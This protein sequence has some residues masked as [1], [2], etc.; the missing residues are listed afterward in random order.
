MTTPDLLARQM[1]VAFHQAPTVQTETDPRDG[2]LQLFEDGL[3]LYH[4]EVCIV[5]SAAANSLPIP[6]ELAI[7][8][9][10][11][12]L[13]PGYDSGKYSLGYIYHFGL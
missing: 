8:F 11:D 6:S 12:V 10:Y 13:I 5:V 9:I 2:R 4:Q 3:G 7:R 1:R